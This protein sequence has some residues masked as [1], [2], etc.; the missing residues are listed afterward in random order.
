M[1][2]E[3]S[4]GFWTAV[5]AL[6]RQSMHR[7]MCASSDGVYATYACTIRNIYTRMCFILATNQAFP[8]RVGCTSLRGQ[9]VLDN[10]ADISCVKWV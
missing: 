2:H 4:L 5:Y 1:L 8:A 6:T 10:T 9:T 3:T 7:W